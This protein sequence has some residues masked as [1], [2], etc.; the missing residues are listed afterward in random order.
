MIMVYAKDCCSV[1]YRKP[2]AMIM[3]LFYYASLL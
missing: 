2:P 1:D 3:F